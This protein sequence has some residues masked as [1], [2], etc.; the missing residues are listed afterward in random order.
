MISYIPIEV[1]VC[2]RAC[3]AGVLHHDAPALPLSEEPGP[4][5]ATALALAVRATLHCQ[6]QAA[7]VAQ[8]VAQVQLCP[9]AQGKRPANVCVYDTVCMCVQV[10]Q[11]YAM[12]GILWS[13]STS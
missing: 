13:S 11:S 4:S 3:G 9:T 7:C 1:H 5:C 6:W 12:D 2:V 8:L 10:V